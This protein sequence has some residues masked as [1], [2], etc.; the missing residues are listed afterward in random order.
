MS[1]DLRGVLPVAAGGALG[2]AV[3][4]YLSMN[5]ADLE[6]DSNT[7]LLLINESGAFLLGWIAALVGA[8]RGGAF[9][10]FFGTGFMGA[11]TT[12]SSFAHAGLMLGPTYGLLYVVSTLVSGIACAALGL[13]SGR[14]YL[15][16]R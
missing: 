6:L 14:L 10:L 1:I 7:V 5:A 15:S 2:A 11:F 9:Y 4:A 3:R 13:V 16:K 12:F 8:N